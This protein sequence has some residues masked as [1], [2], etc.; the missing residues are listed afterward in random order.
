VDLS[1]ALQAIQAAQL[2]HGFFA[3][4]RLVVSGF[5]VVELFLLGGDVAPA[6]GQLFLDQLEFL[7]VQV[8]VGLVSFGDRLQVGGHALEQLQGLCFGVVRVDE[9]VVADVNELARLQDHV[10]PRPLV[11]DDKT[12]P[13]VLVLCSVRHA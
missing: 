2:A 7:G 12:K 4:N 6:L 5:E 10:L 9:R 13:F 11:H 1:F 3:R 8:H